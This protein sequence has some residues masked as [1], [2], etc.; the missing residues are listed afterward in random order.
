MQLQ[1]PDRLALLQDFLL[2]I[3]AFTIKDEKLIA[4]IELDVVG[5]TARS[6][7]GLVSSADAHSGPALVRLTHTV[8]LMLVLVIFKFKFQ[9]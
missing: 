4:P 3:L 1:V 5:K 2:L 8:C 7:I 9:F 6:P